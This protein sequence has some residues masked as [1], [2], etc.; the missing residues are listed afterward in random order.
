MSFAHRG[1]SQPPTY[2][3]HW[4]FFF[5]ILKLWLFP[6][7]ILPHSDNLIYVFACLMFISPTKTLTPQICLLMD[8]QDATQ[9]LAHSR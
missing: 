6:M 8:S 2:V 7:W 5:L 3:D 4:V 9:C 1:L